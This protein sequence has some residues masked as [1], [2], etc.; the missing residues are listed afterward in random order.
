MI[1]LLD[2]ELGRPVQAIKLTTC[3]QLKYLAE[4]SQP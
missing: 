4:A 2:R 3:P 1:C